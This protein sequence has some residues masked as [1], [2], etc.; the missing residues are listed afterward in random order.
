MVGFALV[1]VFTDPV[2]KRADGLIVQ[3]QRMGLVWPKRGHADFAPALQ[4]GRVKDEFIFADDLLVQRFALIYVISHDV[5]LLRLDLPVK[6]ESSI[7][8]ISVLSVLRF[9]PPF[10]A[11]GYRALFKTM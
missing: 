3:N 5:L 7:S 6:S 10:P 11:V 2:H 1:L 9:Q 4:S 8:G